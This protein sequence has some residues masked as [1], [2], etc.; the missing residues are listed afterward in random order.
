M[1]ELMTNVVLADDHPLI[2]DALEQ[3]FGMEP[4][5]AVVERCTTTDD[6]VE[7]IRKHEPE[8]AVLDLRMP[9]MTGMAMIAE[10]T[11]LTKVVLLT[12][13]ISDEE[14]RMALD[15]GARGLI[16]KERAAEQLIECVTGVLAGE[17]W[18]D[19]DLARR[20]LKVVDGNSVRSPLSP[21]ETEITRCVAE[22]LRNKEIA[23]RLAIAEGT[24]KTHLRT[25]FEK[26]GVESR[27]ALVNW[28]RAR[29]IV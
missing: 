3:L 29:G 14:I 1:V 18:V 8:V 4:G 28:A 6:A 16:L 19:P 5:Y 23:E 24:V 15:L 2:L 26:V 7:A 22:G 20:A 25:I 12:A 17:R 11:A 27:V 9:G 21:R 10:A 13:A